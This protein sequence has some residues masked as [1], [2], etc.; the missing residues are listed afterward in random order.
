M[1]SCAHP[2]LEGLCWPDD[3]RLYLNDQPVFEVPALFEG[4]HRKRRSERGFIITPYIGRLAGSSPT[5]IQKL[6]LNLE[7]DAKDPSAGK[8]NNRRGTFQLCLFMV[9]EQTPQELFREVLSQN[10][11]IA[12]TG[13][14]EWPFNDEAEP[15]RLSITVLDTFTRELIEHPV[16]GLEC[17]HLQCFDLKPFLYLTHSSASRDWKC[18]LCHSDVRKMLID[19]YQLELIS[20]VKKGE[21]LPKRIVFF[22]NGGIDYQYNDAMELELESDKKIV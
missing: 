16:R 7:I 10:C 22:R 8:R 17:K 14:F 13:P 3:A 6:K 20:E 4:H 5:A 9:K 18:P 21:V 2:N 11:N 12:K 19:K 1:V 15:D